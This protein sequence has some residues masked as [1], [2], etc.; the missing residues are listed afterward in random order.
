MRKQR[1]AI[2][3]AGRK[4]GWKER[5]A[6]DRAD[7]RVFAID[8]PVTGLDFHHV[9]VESHDIDGEERSFALF[10]SPSLGSDFLRSD[11][12]RAWRLAGL[13]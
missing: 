13:S 8:A 9:E 1:T 11:S 7:P 12:G 2:S 10:E 6:P 3:A 5:V 4:R